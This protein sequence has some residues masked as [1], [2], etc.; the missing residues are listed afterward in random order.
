MHHVS[1]LIAV[2]ETIL[3]SIQVLIFKQYH[4]LSTERVVVL[5]NTDVPITELHIDDEV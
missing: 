4:N 2:D 1:E 3:S 5:S